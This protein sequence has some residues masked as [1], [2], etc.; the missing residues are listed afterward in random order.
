[1][2]SVQC[3]WCEQLIGRPL[4]LLSLALCPSCGAPL[5]QRRHLVSVVRSASLRDPLRPVES[6]QSWREPGRE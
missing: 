5:P 1:M 6:A 3:P 4:S 2:H